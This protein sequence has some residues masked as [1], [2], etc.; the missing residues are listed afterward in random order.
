M[1][2]A[3]D[4]PLSRRVA[5]A[6]LAHIRHTHTRYDHIRKE[7]GWTNARRIVHQPCLEIL[8]K[9]RG[10]EETGRDMETDVLRELVVITE[11]SDDDETDAAADDSDPASS[12]SSAVKNAANSQTARALSS[13]AS[14]ALSVIR[15]QS[16]GL[17][18]RYIRRMSP[19]RRVRRSSHNFP[20]YKVL[21]RQFEGKS[22]Y[23]ALGA[24]PAQHSRHAAAGGMLPLAGEI[25]TES[26]N[27]ATSLA[28]DEAGS[29]GLRNGASASSI[30]A[31]DGNWMDWRM[32]P[33]V[34][35]GV[36]YQPQQAMDMARSQELR[37]RYLALW[38][39]TE[40]ADDSR[41]PWTPLDAVAAP[42]L[43]AEDVSVQSVEAAPPGASTHPRH[44][45]RRYEHV[46]VRCNS[47]QA[48]LVG[49]DRVF[50]REG[51]TRECHGG[52]RGHPRPSSAAVIPPAQ[53]HG[54][55]QYGRE[56]R[57]AELIYRDKGSRQA[58]VTIPAEHN[59]G[60]Y[61]A[62]RR[63]ETH[64]AG[65]ICQSAHTCRQH[66]LETVGFIE[67]H[68]RD[69][70]AAAR[71]GRGHE[72]AAYYVGRIPSSDA[73]K[74]SRQ[75]AGATHAVY[76]APKRLVIRKQDDEHPTEEVAFACPI[77]QLQTESFPVL[78]GSGTAHA[79]VA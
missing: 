38:P 24:S 47:N 58:Y 56:S 3:P 21:R 66:G 63:V 18:A 14:P 7:C 19:F 48:S 74:S 42:N 57:E 33:V 20:R 25:V 61:R 77:T 11:D 5:L 69:D 71:R 53:Y 27:C 45:S 70:E 44:V 29:T 23:R 35:H 68:R 51:I 22:Q 28:D 36:K 9:W 67:L 55:V 31:H 8:V 10:D 15:D 73:F 30:G 72:E 46:G 60:L 75:A 52:T 78:A 64:H 6:V 26:A 65:A 1:G 40:Q 79:Y 43:Q 62:D 34:G 2:L 76:D 13:V 54:P 32:P 4:L 41:P 37:P 16:C 39:Q 50:E 59:Q 49:R 17:G 12:D